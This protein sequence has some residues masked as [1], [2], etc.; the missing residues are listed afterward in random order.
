MNTERTYTLH[1]I[2]AAI[3]DRE[4]KSRRFLF[5]HFIVIHRDSGRSNNLFNSFVVHIHSTMILWC[6][7]KTA[8]AY[9]IY[10]YINNGKIITSSKRNTNML[11]K[12]KGEETQRR[13]IHIYY[14]CSSGKKNYFPTRRYFDNCMHS[15][16]TNFSQHTYIY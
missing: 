10:I 16:F 15:I 11:A 12:S 3:N 7:D 6:D 1:S 8:L 5:F 4:K 14:I 2:A 13:T 9:F